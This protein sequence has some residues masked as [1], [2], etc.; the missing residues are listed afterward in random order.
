MQ[1]PLCTSGPSF[2]PPE[3]VVKHKGLALLSLAQGI[4]VSPSA[5]AQW[6]VAQP[7]SLNTAPLEWGM[8]WAASAEGRGASFP[9]NL[10]HRPGKDPRGGYRAHLA[11]RSKVRRPQA[12]LTWML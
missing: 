10:R 1:H 8:L 9:P 3:T 5:T 11:L 12:R 6:P 4:L 2:T 7:A